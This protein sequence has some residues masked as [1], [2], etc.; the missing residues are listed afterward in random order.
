M[1]W[2][3][4]VVLLSLLAAAAIRDRK[5]G[6]IPDA[7]SYG[8]T[9]LGLV[10]AYFVSTDTVGNAIRGT[11]L[12]SGGM[13]WIAMV[14]E[15]LTQREGMGFGDVKLSGVLGA[16][17]GITGSIRVISYAAWL[18]VLHETFRKKSSRCRRIPFAPYVFYGAAI[19]E[20]Y[21]LFASHFWIQT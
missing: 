4:H 19:H 2:T 10:F 21:S 1:H 14:F 6:Q 8:G 16:F 18:A 11:L 9:A 3:H 15:S 20:I 13:F 17:L 5:D 12:V 7:I